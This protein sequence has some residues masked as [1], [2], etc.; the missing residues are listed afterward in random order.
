MPERVFDDG[1]QTFIQFKPGQ[2]SRGGI[3]SVLA[4]NA[5]GQNAIINTTFR[6]GYYIVDGVPHKILLLAGKG[7]NGKVVKLVHE[8]N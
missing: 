4:E 1:K 3:P 2:G 6:D 5:A 7:S 8:N